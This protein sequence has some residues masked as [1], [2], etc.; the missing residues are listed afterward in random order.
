VPKTYKNDQ[1]GR[2]CKFLLFCLPKVAYGGG[3][4]KLMAR[5]IGESG[6]LMNIVSKYRVRLT[7]ALV[8][9]FM[10]M[11]MSMV[12]VGVFAQTSS[13][14][15]KWVGDLPIMPSLSIEAGL[16]FAFDSPEGRIVIIYLSGAARADEVAAY[17]DI[18]LDP[19][20]WTNNGGGSWTREGESLTIAK[21]TAG[22]AELWKLKISPE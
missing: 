13:P 15:A 21:T 9:V 16:G 8:G 1:A 11:A 18:A 12:T 14:Q 17:Y 7:T 4:L 3:K 20:G 5:I 22:T 2:P 6:L 19:L 10:L